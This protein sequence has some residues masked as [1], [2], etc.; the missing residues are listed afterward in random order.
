MLVAY[1]GPASKITLH[2]QVCSPGQMLAV[3]FG[4]WHSTHILSADP[5][6]VFNIYAD[7][8][9][10][11]SAHTGRAAASDA[12]LKYRARPALR[13]TALH[14]N[15]KNYRLIGPGLDQARLVGPLPEITALGLHPGQHLA[16]LFL[17]RDGR[18]TELTQRARTYR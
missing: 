16:E 14:D 8:R 6:V 7:V 12:E 15:S 10:G 3:P 1:P 13:V 2:T 17:V 11:N 5:A 18:L 9:P 4:A